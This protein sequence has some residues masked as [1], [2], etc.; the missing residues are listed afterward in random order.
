M[1][2][3]RIDSSKQPRAYKEALSFMNET[4]RNSEASERI[5]GRIRGITAIKYLSRPSSA[6][7]NLTAMATNVPAAMNG[8]GH[9]PLHQTASLLATTSTKYLRFVTGKTGQLT[10]NDQ[11]LFNE[12]QKNG[13][14]ES[15]VNEEAL[16]VGNTFAG[17]G[18]RALSKWSMI[19]FSATERFNRAVTIAATYRG[20]AAQYQT[21]ELTAPKK[22]ELLRQAKDISDKA[23][24]VYGRENLPAWARGSG[25][26]AQAARSFYMFKTFTHNYIQ[27]AMHLLGSRN[28]KAFAWLMLSPAIVGGMSSSPAW[29]ILKAA[30]ML[31]LAGGGGEDPLEAFY[32][33]LERTFGH[34]ASRFGR[35]GLAGLGG[36]NISGSTGIDIE[37]PKD[38]QELLG[39]PW[40]A[41]KDVGQG[42]AELAKGNLLKGM[43]KILPAALASPV[44]AYREATE[45]ITN[46]RNAPVFFGR[47]QLKLSPAGA[48]IRGLG[49]NPADISEKR[50]IIW[51]DKKGAARF[52]DRRSDIYARYRL[53]ILNGRPQDEADKLIEEIIAYNQAVKASGRRDLPQITGKSLKAAISR[54]FTPSRREKE[55]ARSYS[56][57]GY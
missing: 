31:G 39:A 37:L 9:I 27:L 11:W 13:W 29:L 30:G 10:A 38:W 54:S 41:I 43:E 35:Y 21:A 3:R 1:N 5:I 34:E 52:A 42:S 16:R 18:M 6:A 8:L 32:R 14:D 4:L 25:S 36:I 2:E 47:E 49:F 17:N 56:G 55:R 45:G 33:W 53:W 51:Q 19:A 7:I 40:S 15:Q 24:G 28:Y 26:L 12:I 46:T 20:L 23:H 57:S 44:K 22:R 48:V 50:E